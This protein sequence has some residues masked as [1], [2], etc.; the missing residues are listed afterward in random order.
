MEAVALRRRR[1][2]V[3]CD[4]RG[5]VCKGSVSAE[6]DVCLPVME[7]S[8]AIGAKARHFGPGER[9]ID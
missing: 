3:I 2:L 1:A 6:A 8:V 4:G 7:T 9:H 5:F